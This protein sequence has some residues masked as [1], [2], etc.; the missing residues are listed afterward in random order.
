[1]P[2]CDWSS[3]V[4]SSD[5]KTIALTRWT[6]VGTEYW[7][8]FSFPPPGD[9]PDQGMEPV[10]LVSSAW[11]SP[12]SPA[13]PTRLLIMWLRT[14]LSKFGSDQTQGSLALSATLGSARGPCGGRRCRQRLPSG[15]GSTGLGP[16]PLSFLPRGIPHSPHPQEIQ[17]SLLPARKRFQSNHCP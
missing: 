10:S 7:N 3:D 12:L 14:Q 1:M 6:F 16:C 5:L 9:L 17:R 11:T 2:M 8:G 13:L 4:C 15:R